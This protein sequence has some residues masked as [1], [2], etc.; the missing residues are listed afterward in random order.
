MLSYADHTEFAVVYLVD[1]I[2]K[3][4]MIVVL[5]LI[6]NRMY[7]ELYQIYVTLSLRS[8]PV[9]LCLPGQPF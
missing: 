2:C 5:L 6:G 1:D 9:L 8:A 3:L 4:D 7:N